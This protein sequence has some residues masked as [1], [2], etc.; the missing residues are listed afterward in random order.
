[1]NH[2][3]GA[4]TQ[5]D[6]EVAQVGD[7]DGVMVKNSATS[8]TVRSMAGQPPAGSTGRDLRFPRPDCPS[9]AGPLLFWSGTGVRG[10]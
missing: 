4:V 7:A 8:T 1:M 6:P 9:C 10:R 3:S 5:L 2:A